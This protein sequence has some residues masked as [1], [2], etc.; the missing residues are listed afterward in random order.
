MSTDPIGL[1]ESV[2]EPTGGRHWTFSNIKHVLTCLA[3]SQRPENFSVAR[4]LT[5]VQQL[6]RTYHPRR[7][8]SS[9][10]RKRR[11]YMHAPQNVKVGFSGD[12]QLSIFISR[13]SDDV[14][15]LSKE[16][17]V[18]EVGKLCYPTI[19]ITSHV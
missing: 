2:L 8:A 9:P 18:L 17:I 5:A 1:P 7:L 4:H 10:T 15:V 19:E 3:G 16:L 13:G 14:G 12:N 11:I 6:T